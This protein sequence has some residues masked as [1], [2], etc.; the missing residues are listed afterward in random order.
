M[1]QARV[2]IVHDYLN[3]MGGAE[4]VVGVLHRMFPEAPIYTTIADRNKLLPELR[5]AAIHT[6]W[7]QRIPRIKRFFKLFFWLYPFAVRS[8]DLREYDIVISS[9]SAYA[10]GVR[11]SRD[12][13][14]ICYC[15]APM[16]FAWDFE[17][18]MEQVSLPKL[19]KTFAKAIAMPLRAW[20]KANSKKADRVIANSTVVKQ[21]IK[22]YYGLDAPVVY[23]PVELKR[24]AVCEEHPEPYY[25]IVSRLVSYKRIDLAVEACTRL[26]KRLVIVGDGDDRARLE[27]L[28][29]P[30]V[31][32]RGRRSDE[33]VASCM[34]RCQALLFPGLEDFGITPLEA[35]ACGR[36]VIAFRGGGALDTIVSGLNG[37]FFNEQTVESLAEAIEEGERWTWEPQAIRKH[38]EKFNE[39]IFAERLLDCIHFTIKEKELEMEK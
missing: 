12:G 9:S 3:Q 16:R 13:V 36:P 18:Y 24:F 29:G 35:N 34:G 10:K 26:N 2:A 8:I 6:T 7:M 11:I 30:T 1:S 31:E 23:P 17:G 22:Q 32:F 14:H 5:E 37:L 33:E 39:R 28:A 27:R 19:I 21:R 38:A 25:L 15:H 4:R 20:D